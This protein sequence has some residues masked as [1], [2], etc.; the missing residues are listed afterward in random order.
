MITPVSDRIFISLE[1]EKSTSPLIQIKQMLSPSK[2]N[3]GTV[4]AIGSA[5]KSVQKGDKV[6]FHPFDE[7]E[8]PDPNIVVIREKSLLAR[9]DADNNPSTT[10]SNPFK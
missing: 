7:L 8:T 10:P 4:I 3:Q 2:A 6:L 9:I 5:V 1:A